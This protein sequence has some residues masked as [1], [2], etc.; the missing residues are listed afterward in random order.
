MNGLRVDPGERLAAVP[1]TWPAMPLSKKSAD[2]TSALT[3]IVRES[4]SIAAAL[5][6]PS[7]RVLRQDRQGQRLGQREPARILA[8][9]DE[10]RRRGALDVAAVGHEVQVRLQ[11]VPLGVTQ[12]E[13]ERARD[14]HQ[15]APRC[16]GADAVE[17][18]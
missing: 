17:E 2:P 11:D 8:E 12:L 14:L 10:A 7:R 18:A 5:C 6:T 1:F 3:A 13:L 15:L 9:I 16:G 4:T